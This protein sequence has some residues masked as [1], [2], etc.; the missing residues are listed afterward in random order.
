MSLVSVSVVIDIA[1]IIRRVVM[2][3]QY[4]TSF[5]G[6]FRY[7]IHIYHDGYLVDLTKMWFG[8]E[9]NAYIDKL[10]SEGYTKAYSEDE[11]VKA[12]KKYEYLLERKLVKTNNSSCFYN[13]VFA[14]VAKNYVGLVDAINTPNVFGY[15][16]DS[17][18]SVF[19]VTDSCGDVIVEHRIEEGKDIQYFID[20]FLCKHHL[21]NINEQLVSNTDKFKHIFAEYLLS[22]YGWEEWESKWEYFENHYT[23][24][25]E[26]LYFMMFNQF[27]FD[28]YADEV[29]KYTVKKLCQ[30]TRM[31]IFEAFRYMV[32]LIEN[33][34]DALKNLKQHKLI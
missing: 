25:V 29:H 15:Y 13:L 33:P 20:E 24:M 26:L 12:Q 4:M 16:K 6:S 21:I 31:D 32:L 34:D 18:E 1:T 27:V 10:E 22:R 14:G 19:F 5:A 23:I 11:V 7:V 8:D 17:E 3:K 9:L 2:K 28:K 30:T